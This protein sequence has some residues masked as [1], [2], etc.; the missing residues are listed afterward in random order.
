MKGFKTMFLLTA[1]S[2]CL[3]LTACNAD[4]SDVSGTAS[5]EQS[6]SDIS[7]EQSADVGSETSQAVS[8]DKAESADLSLQPTE[9]NDI[10][11][12]IDTSE[13]SA[14][15][16]EPSE[17]ESSAVPPA[18]STEPEPDI[19]KPAEDVSKPEEDISKVDTPAPHTHNYSATTVS[20]TCTEEGYTLHRCNCGDS[21]KDTRKDE[22]GHSFGAWQQEKAP[23]YDEEGIETRKCLRNNCTYTETRNIEKLKE[24]TVY[25][26]TA[27][28]I[29]ETC[30]LV[31]ELLNEERAKLGAPALTTAPIAHEMAMV[32]AQELTIIFEHT[33]PNGTDS[34]TIYREFRYN[35]DDLPD[36]TVNLEENPYY[37]CYMPERSSENIQRNQTA[38]GN[39]QTNKAWLNGLRAQSIV[40]TFELSVQWGTGHWADLMNPNYTGVG[41]GIALVLKDVTDVDFSGQQKSERYEMYVTILTMDKTYG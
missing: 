40:N 7:A 37:R 8:K 38:A 33:R 27:E 11:E 35:P 1:L 18:E 26:I 28:D 24:P 23:T 36:P 17:D 2:I 9:S 13:E 30:N 14:P 3:C 16:E 10:S 4:T 22:Y 5:S 29:E 19:S 31:I 34:S 21:Y 6:Q 20:P 25:T 32:R 15:S 39:G 41:V 12:D